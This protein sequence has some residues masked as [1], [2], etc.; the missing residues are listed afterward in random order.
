MRDSTRYWRSPGRGEGREDV[1]DDSL[2]HH[3]D[4]SALDSTDT[5]SG[6]RMSRFDLVTGTTE[7]KF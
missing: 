4:E 5:G 7:P 2:V 1:V 6:T 3:G